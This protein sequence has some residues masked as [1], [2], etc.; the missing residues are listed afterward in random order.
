MRY[1]H[2]LK[3]LIVGVRLGIGGDRRGVWNSGS[4]VVKLFTTS[5]SNFFPKSKRFFKKDIFSPFPAA[6]SPVTKDAILR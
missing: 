1:R 2:T 5:I 6:F 4:F 3:E